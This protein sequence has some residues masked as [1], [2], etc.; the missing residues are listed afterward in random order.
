MPDSNIENFLT[1]NNDC[2]CYNVH[3]ASS[4][5][6]WRVKFWAVFQDQST[7]GSMGVRTRRSRSLF[8]WKEIFRT[9]GELLGSSSG[10]IALKDVGVV[11]RGLLFE[12]G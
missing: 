9:A 10:S 4:H 6:R 8:S 12:N 2:A 3:S 5:L 11:K 1:P 7:F